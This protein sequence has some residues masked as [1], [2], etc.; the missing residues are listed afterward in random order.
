MLAVFVKFTVEPSQ[1]DG[2]RSLLLA[3]AAASLTDEPGC[4]VFE[5][6]ETDAGDFLLYEIYRSREAFDEHLRSPHY[7]DFSA[8]T[9][10]WVEDKQVWL[11]APLT[12]GR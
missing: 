1:R 8:A 10:T 6:C 3:N 5:V 12:A 11:A 9:G 4:E 7:L 2:F